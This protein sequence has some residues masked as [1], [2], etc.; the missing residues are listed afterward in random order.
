MISNPWSDELLGACTAVA[1]RFRQS[2]GVLADEVGRPIDDADAHLA[3]GIIASRRIAFVQAHDDSKATEDV[4]AVKSTF[5]ALIKRGVTGT[6][7][8]LKGRH[9]LVPRN[10]MGSDLAGRHDVVSVHAAPAMTASAL[11]SPS[12]PTTGL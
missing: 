1:R 7:T 11:T 12:R 4:E 8:V 6:D 5:L 3:A 10:E 2:V 9:E